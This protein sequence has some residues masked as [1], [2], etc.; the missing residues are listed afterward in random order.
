MPLNILFKLL[1]IKI[2]TIILCGA[3]WWGCQQDPVLESFCTN[4]C[5]YVLGVSK[6]VYRSAILADCGQSQLYVD[7]HFKC[8]KF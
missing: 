8:I 4:L 2:N 3:E 1:D 5:K 6:Y 7:G